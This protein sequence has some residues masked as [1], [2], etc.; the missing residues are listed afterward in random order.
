MERNRAGTSIRY[1]K[2]VFKPCSFDIQVRLDDVQLPPER[3]VLAF[4]AQDPAQQRCQS[5][6]GVKRSR[7]CGLDEMAD[8]GQRVEK[9]VR[10]DLRAQRPKLR[11]RGEPAHFLFANL[12]VVPFLRDPDRVNSSRDDHRH[13]LEHDQIV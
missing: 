9:K 6:Q 4:G 3:R 8:G 1:Q 7:R 11:F 2:P 12:A 5:H 13:G 10:I